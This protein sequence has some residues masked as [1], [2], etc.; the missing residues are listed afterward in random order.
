MILNGVNIDE[1]IKQDKEFRK[2]VFAMSFRYFFAYH[3]GWA[4]AAPFENEW[5]MAIEGKKNLIFKAFRGSRKTTKLRAYVVWNLIHGIDPYI[6][7]QSYEGKLSGEWVRQ[8]AKML[9]QESI[10]EDYGKLFPFDA[11]REDI[12][13]SSFSDFETTNGSKIASRSL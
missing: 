12:S 9:M 8:V 2:R 13:K 1:E 4:N 7:V 6:I 11:K 5:N 3:F 10:I